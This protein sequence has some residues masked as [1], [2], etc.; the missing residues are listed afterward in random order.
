MN[1]RKSCH[2][3]LARSLYLEGLDH[4]PENCRVKAASGDFL[5]GLGK[6]RRNF[7]GASVNKGFPQILHTT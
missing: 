1:D 6:S 3:G 4:E 5:A 7:V 2:N